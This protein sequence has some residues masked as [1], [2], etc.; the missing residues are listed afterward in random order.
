[1]CYSANASFMVG[2]PLVMIGLYCASTAYR[3]NR[4]YLLFSMIPFLFG[5]QQMIEGA[6]WLSLMAG[7]TVVMMGFAYAYLWF[8]F[9]LWPSYMPL[10]IYLIEPDLYRKKIIK[11]CMVSGWIIGLI[12]YVPI[13]SGL[14]PVNVLKVQHSICYDAYQSFYF[15]RTFAFLYSV[16]LILPMFLSTKRSLQIL[17]LIS[18]ASLF[19]SYWWLLYAFTS[20]WCFAE[21]V[22]SAGIVYIIY[23]LKC[24][25][26]VTHAN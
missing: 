25:Q 16:I 11:G 14:I 20:I 1:M 4:A 18:F 24:P 13:I 26:F 22:I 12:L 17:G 8:A 23:Q 5:I 21:A 19:I 15:L 10:S 7:Q 9:F 2:A 6:V 3:Y